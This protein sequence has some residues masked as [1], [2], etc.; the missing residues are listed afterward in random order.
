MN[1]RLLALFILTTLVASFLP[2]GIVGY[3][4]LPD[5]L[6]LSDTIVIGQ[7]AKIDAEGPTSGSIVVLLKETIKGREASGS[8]RVLYKAIRVADA[9]RLENRRVLMFLARDEDGAFH[10]VPVAHGSDVLLDQSLFLAES[11]EPP[12]LLPSHPGDSPLQKVIKA[13]ASIQADSKDSLALSM[14]M[15]LAWQQQTRSDLTEAF[16]AIRGSASTTARTHGT[17][18]LVAFGGLDGLRAL[19]EDVSRGQLDPLG[20]IELLERVYASEDRAGIEIL[21]RWLRPSA[22]P[23]VRAAAAG[24][25]ARIHTPAA[26]VVLGPALYDPEFEVRWRAI[27]AFSMFANNVPIG[28]AG[29]APGAWPF[30]SDSTFKFSV[31]DPD[32]IRKDEPRYLEFWRAWWVDHRKA[33]AELASDP[34]V[35]N[36]G[37]FGDGQNF[38]T[39]MLGICQGETEIPGPSDGRKWLRS[40]GQRFRTPLLTV[41]NFSDTT[42][43]VNIWATR[44]SGSKIQRNCATSRQ[45]KRPH[46]HGAGVH[47]THG[48]I[49]RA[50][51]PQLRR[52]PHPRP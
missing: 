46:Q 31:A 49:Q 5:L 23:S 52:L 45:G 18:G 36:F 25:L 35:L 39:F 11:A 37:N 41:T 1:S 51:I 17:T 12:S 16:R 40:R 26:I 27:G 42:E 50:K 44:D 33:V 9:A 2:A 38:G 20:N 21:S 7:L 47:P 30:S 4:S 3:R 13:L 22:H 48:G 28:G 10:L 24:A 29:P 19:D 8:I 43:S 15:S 14:L 34:K 32:V 6:A